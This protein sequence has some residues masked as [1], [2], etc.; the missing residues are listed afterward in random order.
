MLDIAKK[1]IELNKMQRNITLIKQE[2]LSMEFDDNSFDIVICL[3]NTLGNLPT[4]NIKHSIK[5]RLKALQE[6]NRILSNKGKLILSVYNSD[7]LDLDNYG[8]NFKVDYKNSIL[9]NND[10][11]LSFTLKKRE[12]HFFYSHWFT[13]EEIV[14]LLE[15]NNFMVEFLE[16]RKERIITVNNKIGKYNV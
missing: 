14:Q 9:A 1:N 10:I 15:K 7:K 4:N 6:M 5:K 2:I 11:I 16:F 8:D 13:K 3:N 12:K